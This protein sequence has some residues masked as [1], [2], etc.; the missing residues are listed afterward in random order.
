MSKLMTQA[1]IQSAKTAGAAAVEAD[2]RG[3]VT[4]RA[5]AL[6][7]LFA[8]AGYWMQPR[9]LTTAEYR[10]DALLPKM[11]RMPHGARAVPWSS[12]FKAAEAWAKA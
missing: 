5:Q 6:N 1:E 4:A 3:D 8:A 2:R 9:T 12:R 7:D 11:L 10:G